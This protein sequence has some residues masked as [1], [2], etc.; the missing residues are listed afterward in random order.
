MGILDFIVDDTLNNL[1]SLRL[2]TPDWRSGLQ[3]LVERMTIDLDAPLPQ[4]D[5]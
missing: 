2:V 1:G 4:D 3:Q 5:A